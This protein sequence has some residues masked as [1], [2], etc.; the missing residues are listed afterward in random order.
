MPWEWYRLKVRKKDMR[1]YTGPDF[2]NL[3]GCNFLADLENSLTVNK[4]GQL[5]ITAKT[6]YRK[7][8]MISHMPGPLKL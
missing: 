5:W 4:V 7:L 8:Q 1:N 2:A 6:E 3:L